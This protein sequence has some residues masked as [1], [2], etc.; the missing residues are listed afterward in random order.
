MGTSRLIV[1][2]MNGSNCRWDMLS[3]V[4]VLD[5]ASLL[6]LFSRWR[7]I[8]K[9]PEGWRTEKPGG[10]SAVSWGLRR[11]RNFH[12]GVP[13]KESIRNQPNTCVGR[14]HNRKVLRSRDVCDSKR[15]PYH[16]V[17]IQDALVVAGPR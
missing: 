10:D 14:W 12:G 13:V 8:L 5:C 15:V 11:V 7:A 16:H 4:R 9:A 2:Q 17:F 3:R 6:A 1:P